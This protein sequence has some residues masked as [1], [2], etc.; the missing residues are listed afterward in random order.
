MPKAY[1]CW[2][3][4]YNLWAL[5]DYGRW[6]VNDDAALCPEAHSLGRDGVVGLKPIVCGW[7][8]A[9]LQRIGL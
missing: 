7:V 1:E 8:F 5:Q 4:P 6:A 2:N 3:I 9:G